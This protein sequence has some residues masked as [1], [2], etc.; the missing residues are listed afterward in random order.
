[1]TPHDNGIAAGRQKAPPERIAEIEEELRRIESK[2]QALHRELE[3]LRRI[4]EPATVHQPSSGGPVTADEKIALF[5]S[6]FR[7][8]ESVFPRLW[9][10]PR[11]GKKGYSPVCLNEWVRGIC[12]KPRVKCAECLS[13]K[14]PPL[15]E[16][17][18]LA[19]LIGKHTIGTYAIRE[20]NTCVF[21]AADFDGDGWEADV[22]AY[23]EA[24]ESLGIDVA[25]E[26]SRSGQGAHG[27][28][29]FASPAPAS[30]ARRLGTLIT[31]KASSLHA[32]MKLATYDRFFPNQ[33]TLPDGGFGNL[34]ALPLQKGPREQGNTVFLD[35]DLCAISDQWEYLASIRRMTP[36]A[37]EQLLETVVGAVQEKSPEP[38]ESFALRFDEK[39]LDIIPEA[40]TKGVFTGTIRVRRHTQLELAVEGLPPCLIAAVK[41]LATLANPVFYEKQ[42][43]RFPTYNIPRFIFCGA[44]RPGV[45]VLPRG[46]L[47]A[48]KTLVRKAGG[49]LNIADERPVAS[50]VSFSFVGDL[51][52]VQSEAVR[53][54]MEH[55][56][57]VLMAPPGAGKT[58]MACSIIAQRATSTLVLV[59]RKTL[60]EQWRERIKTFL[61]LEES[62]I[63][64][65]GSTGADSLAPVTLGML[66]T[67]TRS[68]FPEAL[69]VP[70]SHIVIDECH[71]V[72][73]A[74]IEAVVKKTSARFILGLTATPVRKDGLQKLLFLQC[75][76][77]RHTVELDGDEA[78]SRKLI[79]RDLLLRRDP[80]ES[81]LP[82]HLLWEAIVNSD[83]RNQMIVADIASAALE[84]RFSAVLSDRKEHLQH[85]ETLVKNSIPA[86]VAMVFRIDG[87]LNMKQ[88][89]ALF[90]ELH[91]RADAREP[92]VL[93][94]TSSLLGEG[95]DLPELDTL[96][97]AM[98]ISFK[99]RIIQY[100]G[101]LH[102]RCQGKTE[103]RVYDYVETD[104]PLTAHMHR[105]R[106][107]AFR[108]MGYEL[109]E[110]DPNGVFNW[111]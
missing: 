104:N 73:A 108:Q 17:A 32:G 96:F 107:S 59:H 3:D 88:R 52:A 36:D 31:A 109:V 110:D 68:E 9:Q 29:F 55:D 42:R 89:A 60:L 21:L 102:R 97:L 56:E 30:Q 50:K 72:P 39:V 10:N 78:V 12:E 37:L 5:L 38:Q 65:L 83:E 19:H 20:D 16:N 66:Q 25:V 71:H 94:A 70:Y 28:I 35:K 4:P 33:D 7:C 111:G 81:R 27:W 48:L 58:V 101:R 15:D 53:E 49:K 93:L 92:F 87:S 57:G 18:V 74:S 6:L 46:T 47:P 41:R 34:I 80:A 13:Q 100:A 77:I 67:L 91:R 105:K 95:F 61:G 75:G 24:A 76:P 51:T 40:V 14:F 26:R 99:G 54:V 45:I 82:I 69:L 1:M 11:S 86:D 8:R 103:V 63:A 79:V 44:L 64:V 23:R 85:L 43:L 22:T 106:L 84:K 2:K 98:P 90:D 62:S